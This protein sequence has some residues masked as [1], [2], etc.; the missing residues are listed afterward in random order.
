M[1]PEQFKEKRFG[2]L[3]AFQIELQK[4]KKLIKLIWCI[5]VILKFICS[6]RTEYSLDAQKV[7]LVFS[8]NT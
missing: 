3:K 4:L 7:G 5:T 8:A 6:Q 2:N 1:M